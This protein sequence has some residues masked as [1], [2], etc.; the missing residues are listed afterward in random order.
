M[1]NN[2]ANNKRIARNTMYLY[3][4]M[5]LLV[6]VNFYTTRVVL[7][8]LG[9]DDFG[10]YN[11]VAGFV[12]MI[13]FMNQSMTNSIQRFYNFELG[14]GEKSDLKRYFETA[15]L[16]QLVITSV[17]LLFTET[18]GLWFLN[19]KMVIPIHRIH[20]TKVVYQCSLLVM[21]VTTLEV[22]FNAIIIAKEKMN[23]YA[24]VSLIEAAGQLF[25]AYV[26]SVAENGRLEL[27]A[28]L[29]LGLSIIKMACNIIYS[30][31]LIPHLKI[32]VAYYQ[33]QLREVLSFSGWNLFGS[34]S[35]VLKS[36]GINVLMNMFFG[37]AVNAAR[38]IAYQVLSCLFKLV[39]NFQVAINPQIV[40]S[41]SMGDFGRYKKLTMSSAKIS[42]TLMWFLTLPILF[43]S[44]SLLSLW[45]GDSVPKY[46]SIFLKIILLTGLVDS[47]G[48]AISVPIYA[49]GK[50]KKYQVIVS[51]IIMLILPI[52]Y[53]VYKMGG[54]PTLSMWISLALSVVAQLARVIIWSR[55]VHIHWGEYVKKI[56]LPAVLIMAISFVCSLGINRVVDGIH[57]S[58]VIFILLTALY[59]VILN[60]FCIYTLMLSSSEK[61]FILNLIRKIFHKSTKIS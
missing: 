4:R 46:A 43:C 40:Q 58:K 18:I 59:T 38:G 33:E 60:S 44:D 16:A 47:L 8:N 30:K 51:T 53:V 15:L 55:L 27:Y 49:T 21:I 37:V 25:I 34:A 3:F 61:V 10:L 48:A 22:P 39:G 52:S 7:H 11:V 32:R 19:N 6:V 41:Y 42:F 57:N 20:S 5:L 36:Q 50:I 54:S 28:S 17:I 13:A 2:S 14:Q 26:I 56:I 23:F 1:S 45:L 9:V 24:A 35:G 29:L 12:S 31:R